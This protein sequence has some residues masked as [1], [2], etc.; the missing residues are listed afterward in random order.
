MTYKVAITSRAESD[1]QRAYEWYREN[2]SEEYATRWFNGISE[3]M[4]SLAGHPEWCSTASEN[5]RFQFKLYELDY[6]TKRNKHRILF[7]IHCDIVL[8]MHIRHSA[9]REL[10]AGDL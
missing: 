1:R 9:Q 5:H 4:N 6:G 3:A 7:R 8:V 10:T 2:Y